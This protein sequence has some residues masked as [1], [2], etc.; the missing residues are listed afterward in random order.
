MLRRGLDIGLRQPPAGA[1]AQV[2]FGFVE[3]GSQ[4]SLSRADVGRQPAFISGKRPGTGEL[5]E[6]QVVL[7][8]VSPERVFAQSALTHLPNEGV[9]YIARPLGRSGGLQALEDIHAQAF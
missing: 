5:D 6:E 8:Q 3:D 4:A 7:H 9:V 1:Q 2:Q